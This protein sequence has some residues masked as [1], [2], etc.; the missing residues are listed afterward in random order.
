MTLR[1]MDQF[2]VT[3]ELVRDGFDGP[4]RQIILPREHYRA[5]DLA[6]EPDA[7]A[8][9]Y[10]LAAAAIRPGARVKIEGLGSRSLQGD[11]A[12]SRRY[13]GTWGPVWTLR[14]SK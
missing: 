8:A 5:E 12:L 4:P 2:G 13:C 7:T 1:L 6:I 14:P 9:S 11:V 3:P 10:F